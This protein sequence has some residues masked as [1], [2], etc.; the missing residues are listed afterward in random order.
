[1]ILKKML[2]NGCNVEGHANVIVS[3]STQNICN[4]PAIK[5]FP[6]KRNFQLF[7]VIREALFCYRGKLFLVSTCIY[8]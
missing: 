3:Q 8:L 7:H 5:N 4:D 2:W 6:T 1:M